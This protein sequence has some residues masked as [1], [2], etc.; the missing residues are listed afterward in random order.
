MVEYSG[1]IGEIFG[2]YSGDIRDLM[3][4]YSGFNGGIFGIC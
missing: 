1:F 3:V 2:M 4:E